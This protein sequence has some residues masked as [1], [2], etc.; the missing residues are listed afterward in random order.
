MIF[1][2]VSQIFLLVVAKVERQ[3]APKVLIRAYI[4]DACAL[5]LTAPLLSNPRDKAMASIQRECWPLVDLYLGVLVQRFCWPK[6]TSL[7]CT[8]LIYVTACV[9]DKLCRFKEEE[10][11]E[12]ED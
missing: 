12:E 4:T 8:E 9:S 5:A 2:L 7:E 6:G 10:E 11:E 1:T 3:G